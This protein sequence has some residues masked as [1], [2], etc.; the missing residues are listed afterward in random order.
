M[1]ILSFITQTLQYIHP[2]I[3]HI[4][5]KAGTV[6]GGTGG[7]RHGKR[8]A[9]SVIEEQRF[10][11]ELDTPKRQRMFIGKTSLIHATKYAV[12]GSAFFSLFGC[13]FEGS[14]ILIRELAAAAPAVEQ[15]REGGLPPST[16]AR[17]VLRN[18]ADGVASMIAAQ[19]TSL[20]F[21]FSF[22]RSAGMPLIARV[23]GACALGSL[24]LVSGHQYLQGL[25]PAL[26][27]RAR[28]YEK[29]RENN[30]RRAS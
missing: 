7:W 28:H 3:F 6:L 17:Q 2:S 14:R 8:Y 23:S 5:F 4:S 24:A 18:H 26:E 21:G 13:T 12:V 9:H 10:L 30:N 29:E 27:E 25:L 11:Q 20:L 22:F 16:R 19:I 1:F 15:E